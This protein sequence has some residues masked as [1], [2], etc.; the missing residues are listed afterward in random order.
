MT[1]RGLDCRSSILGIQIDSISDLGPMGTW[2]KGGRRVKLNSHLHLV[3]RSLPRFFLC[4]CVMWCC[5]PDQFWNPKVH[6]K[7]PSPLPLRSL[8]HSDSLIS[9]G[10]ILILPPIYYFVFRLSK[11]RD[12]SVGIVTRVR[13]ERSGFSGSIPGGGWEFFS[14]PLR[15]ERLW[16]PPSL[17]S[18]GCRGLFPWGKAAGAWSWPLTSI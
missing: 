2:C 12:G 11:S 1:G 6:Y 17:L 10:T 4:M 13:V 5:T 18:N 16:G 9:L 15:P 14:S 7:T 3:P 8:L